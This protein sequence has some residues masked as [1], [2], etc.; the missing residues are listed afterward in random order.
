ME[1]LELPEEVRERVREARRVVAFSG[2]GVSRESGLDTFRGAGGLWERMR[3]E[4]MATPQAFRADPAK[5]W[6]WYAWRWG[7]ASGAQPNPAHLA[8]VRLEEVFP[9]FTLVTQNVDGLHIRAGSRNLLEL[10]GTILRAHCNRCGKSRDM[11]EAIAESPEEPPVCSCGGKFRPSVVWFGES[12]PEDVLFRASAEASSCHVFLSVGTSSTVYPAA[13]L[14]ELAH[15]A[16]ACLI[17][18]NP[19]PTPFSGLMDLRLAAPAGEA[20]P[21]LVEAMERCR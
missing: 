17:E 6:Q 11:G 21:A 2:A 10:H 14:I 9:S 7:T 3:P 8:L 18:V 5:V 19:E 20:V 12:L 4:E 1:P 15:Q 16:G 13:G